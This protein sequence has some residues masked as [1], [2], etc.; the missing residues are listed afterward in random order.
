[1]TDC[2][3]LIT[4]TF[5]K[6]LAHAQDCKTSFILKNKKVKKYFLHL[7]TL[8]CSVFKVMLK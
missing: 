8:T 5:N 4:N 3:G 1:M 2:N 6:E 7:K